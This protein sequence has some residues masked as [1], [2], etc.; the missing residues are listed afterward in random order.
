MSIP[1]SKTN[2]ICC[3]YHPNASLIE[4]CKAGDQICPECGLVVGDRT[5]DVSSEWR[6]FSNKDEGDKDRSRVGGVENPLLD[7]GLST[8]IS[9][10]LGV[11]YDEDGK[12]KYRNK[13]QL[14][15]ADRNKINAFREIENMA[16][17]INLTQDI[18]SSAMEIYKRVYESKA[19]KGKNSDAIIAASVYIA[20]R[21]E[22]VPRTFKEI[23]AV[24]RISK[25]EIG[26]VFKA[27]V[28]V[29]EEDLK[30]VNAKDLL[31]RFCA[32]LQLPLPVRK[33]ANH[34]CSKALEKYILPG[35]SHVTVAAATIYMAACA[36]DFHDSVS[37]SEKK[38]SAGPSISDVTGVADQTIRS[39]YKILFPHVKLLFPED[40][41]FNDVISRLPKS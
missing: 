23:C 37:L 38:P 7:G 19:L 12:L 33:L 16:H 41:D 15:A 17:K 36:L 35:K 30:T 4:D 13:M 28:N 31:A 26:R 39:T 25:K 32:N 27:M 3:P 9:G 18:I 14:S 6:T 11:M 24:S 34:I 21:K 2:V 40:S 8:A 22:G 29:L 1:H 20:C 5:I 10:D